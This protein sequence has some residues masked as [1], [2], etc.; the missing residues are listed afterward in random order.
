MTF[1][2]QRCNPCTGAVPGGGGSLPGATA[3]LRAEG[4]VRPSVAEC[5]RHQPA[6]GALRPAQRHNTPTAA[7]CWF[8]RLT[9]VHRLEGELHQNHPRVS[10]P[11]RRTPPQPRCGILLA[12]KTSDGLHD[13]CA[14]LTRGHGRE[15]RLLLFVPEIEA[16]DDVDGNL[17]GRV[18]TKSAPWRVSTTYATHPGSPYTIEYSV[19]DLSGNAALPIVQEIHVDCSPGKQRCPPAEG[20]WV[21]ACSDEPSMC[22]WAYAEI[23][24][25]SHNSN[26][27]P[28]LQLLGDAHVTI[29]AG[30]PY[31]PCDPQTPP[32]II[33]E[34]G[35]KAFD[36]TDGTLTDG[37]QVTPALIPGVGAAFGACARLR[38]RR[39]GASCPSPLSSMEALRPCLL[40]RSAPPTA[41]VS[42]PMSLRRSALSHAI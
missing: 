12:V 37:I 34:R 5:I 6:P 19:S 29:P 31:L 13:C 30:T 7:E 32:T 38:V 14:C 25:A 4:N 17:L 42:T 2:C 26:K 28:Q 18:G 11:R 40:R 21:A 36:E 10:V 16:I 9:S 23:T 41:T 8:V 1:S 27:A 15:C 20:V 33:C 39:K 22:E 35:A 3:L 24:G